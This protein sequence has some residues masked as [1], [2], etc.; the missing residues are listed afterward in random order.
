MIS[1]KPLFIAGCPRSGTSALARYLNRHQKILVC[2]ERYKYLFPEKITPSLFTFERIL[3]YRE[4]ETN[5]PRELHV[6]L[7]ENKDPARL[8]WIGDKRP[9]YFRYLRR[10]LSNNPGARF[11]IIHRPVE[12]VAESFQGRARD[13]ED[14]WPEDFGFE[15]GV[16]RWNLA[17]KYIREFVESD[18]NP[19]VLVVGY[20]DFFH[21]NEDCI[22][23]ISSFL[24][25]EFD[26]S[27]RQ[28]W[29]E[30]SREFESRRRAKT[31]PTEEQHAFAR[32]NKDHAN[33]EW[34]L[35]LIERQR[36]GSAQPPR[37]AH[38]DRQ[39]H[40]EQLAYLERC[41]KQER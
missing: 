37:S 16:L 23:L 4:G 11:I 5:I 33:E 18:L 28:E 36:S 12:E 39:V 31:S 10:I 32:E 17:L 15:A 25:I 8:K 6:K 20:H 30:M 2:I 26:G 29:K 13:P 3:D 19:N 9:A 14:S 7:L 22:P 1:A 40:E 24:E 41:L 27:V 21:R 34:I 35:D 38:V